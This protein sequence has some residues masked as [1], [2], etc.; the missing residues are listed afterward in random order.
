MPVKLTSAVA[1]FGLALFTFALAGGSAQAYQDSPSAQDAHEFILAVAQRGGLRDA[2][3]GSI[4]QLASG[5]CTTTVQAVGPHWRDTW[6]IDWA[7]ISQ[8]VAHDTQINLVGPVL[9]DHRHDYGSNSFGDGSF[10][11]ILPSG[12]GPRVGAAMEVIRA[13]CDPLAGAPF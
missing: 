7:R 1:R 5:G 13:S 3:R 8:V 10:E 12:M 9:D 11:M 6:T 2:R 4:T